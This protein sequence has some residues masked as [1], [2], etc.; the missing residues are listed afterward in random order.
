M[1][2]SLRTPYVSTVVL[3]C[4]VLY[5]H[6]PYLVQYTRDKGEPRISQ[7]WR[8]FSSFFLLPFASLCQYTMHLQK[9]GG[10]EYEAVVENEAA[11]FLK[12]YNR[13]ILQQSVPP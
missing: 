4:T 1:R 2:T 10:I 7:D 6:I 8:Y 13:A 9:E 3:Y 5:G 12:T 11:E